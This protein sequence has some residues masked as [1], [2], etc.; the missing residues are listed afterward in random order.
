MDMLATRDDLRGT[1][2]G[3]ERAIDALRDDVIAELRGTG[4]QLTWSL[5]TIIGVMN[6]IVFTALESG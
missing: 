2:E 5:A 4:R 1:R 3:L 6:T